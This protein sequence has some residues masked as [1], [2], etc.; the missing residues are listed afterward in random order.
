MKRAIILSIVLGWCAGAIAQIHT[1]RSEE[2]NLDFSSEQ[3]SK[4]VISWITPE[5]DGV[6]G[7]EVTLKIGVN[8]SAKIRHVEIYINGQPLGGSRGL[9]VVKS[10]D[11]RFDEV[12]EKKVRLKR[13]SND[14]KIIAEN[15]NGEIVS[16][17]RTIDYQY[18]AVAETGSD[19]RRDFALI[20]ATDE[21]VEWGDLVNPVNDATTIAAELQDNYGFETELVTNVSTDEVLIKLRE[22]AEKSYLPEDQLFIFFAGHGQF[23]ESFKEGFIVGSNSLKE[24][25]A[26]SS[27]ISHSVLRSIVDRISCEHILLAMDVCFGGTFDPTIATSGYRGDDDMYQDIDQREFIKRKLRYKTRRY[28][29]SGGKEY[30]PDGR[31]GHHSPFARKFLDALRSFGG[32]DNILTLGELISYVEKTSPEPKFGEFGTNAPGSDFIFVAR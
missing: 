19:T 8:T 22:Y 1:Q 10:D 25:L 13:G 18:D 16:E 32:V 21:Y 15:E 14:V 3:E 20:F 5:N 26:K 11:E 6:E 4:I 27:Y 28:L 31:P 9:G 7:S 30:V 2:F 24:D 17:T 23:D 29:T 12:V